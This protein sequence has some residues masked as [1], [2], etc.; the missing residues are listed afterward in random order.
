[1]PYRGTGFFR[2]NAHC[3]HEKRMAA[4]SAEKLVFAGPIAACV[5][6][7][8]L[9]RMDRPSPPSINLSPKRIRSIYWILRFQQSAKNHAS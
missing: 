9:I 2:N 5:L 3:G 8:S 7:L 1:M 6:L 4:I